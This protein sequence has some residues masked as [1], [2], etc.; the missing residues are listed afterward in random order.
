MAKQNDPYA[1]FDGGEKP[2]SSSEVAKSSEADPYARFEVPGKVQPP[3]PSQQ[4]AQQLAPTDIP[5]QGAQREAEPEAPWKTPLTG[6]KTEQEKADPLLKGMAQTAQAERE[7]AAQMRQSLATKPNDRMAWAMGTMKE[8]ASRMGELEVEI[9]RLETAI[10]NQRD[11]APGVRAKWQKTLDAATAEARAMRPEYDKALKVM[12]DNLYAEVSAMIDGKTGELYDETSSGGRVPNEDKVNE[13]TERLLQKYGMQLVT[14]KTV[15]MPPGAGGQTI[16]LVEDETVRPVYDMARAK[17]HASIAYA[18]DEKA[19]T[20]H[21]EK[22]IEERISKDPRL[23]QFKKEAETKRAAAIAKAQA[24]MDAEAQAFANQVKATA[25]QDVDAAVAPVSKQMLSVKAGFEA[26]DKAVGERADAVQAEY[27]AGRITYEQAQQQVA[28][29][30]SEADA[31]VKEANAE[32]ERLNKQML[33]SMSQVNAKYNKAFKERMNTLQGRVNAELASVTEQLSKEYDPVLAKEVA[34]IYANLY[35]EYYDAKAANRKDATISRWRSTWSNPMVAMANIPGVTRTGIELQAFSERFVESLGSFVKMSSDPGSALYNLGSRMET[36]SGLHP[37]ELKELGDIAEEGNIGGLAGETLGGMAVPIGASIAVGAATMGAGAPVALGVGLSSFASWATET[38]SLAQGEYN[39]AISEGKGSAQAVLNRDRLISAQVQAMGLYALDGLPFVQKALSGIASRG[40]RMLVAGATEFAT[41]VPQELTQGVFE[42]NI[43]NNAN[44]WDNFYEGLKR[45]ANPM[46]A[47]ASEREDWSAAKQTMLHLAFVPF[48]GAAGQVNSLSNK[49]EMDKQVMTFIAKTAMPASKQDRASW[50]ADATVNQSVEFAG[51]TIDS[52]HMSGQITATESAEL[53]RMSAAVDEAMFSAKNAGVKGRNAQAL[54]SFTAN[55]EQYRIMAETASDPVEKKAAEA[56]ANA[57]SNIAAEILRTGEASYVEM[58]WP[59]SK[60]SFYEVDEFKRLLSDVGFA[61]LAS[62]GLVKISPTGRAAGDISPMLEVIK[63]E[64]AERAAAR[65]KAAADA[66]QDSERAAAGETR[67]SRVPKNPTIADVEGFRVSLVTAGKLVEGYAYADGQTLVVETEAGV[68]YE[69]GNLEQLASEPASKFGISISDTRGSFN[70]NDDGS[71][72]VGNNAYVNNNENVLDAVEVDS[73]GNIIAVTLAT[74]DSGATGAQGQGYQKGSR[75]FKGQI[76]EDMAYEFYLQRIEQFP[77]EAGERFNNIINNE[78]ESHEAERRAKS[79]PR[80]AP[81]AKAPAGDAEADQGGGTSGESKPAGDQGKQQPAA[82]EEPAQGSEE[83]DGK[84][85]QADQAD[86]EEQDGDQVEASEYGPNASEH[87]DSRSLQ[88]L[89][90]EVDQIEA[91]T[92]EKKASRSRVSKALRDMANAMDALQAYA[93]I[94]RVVVHDTRESFLEA[95]KKH[96]GSGSLSAMKARG[97]M[98]TESGDIHLNVQALAENV[99]DQQSEAARQAAPT[100]EAAHVV[101]RAALRRNPKLGMALHADIKLMAK[102][103]PQVRMMLDWIDRVYK[104]RVSDHV[105]REEAIVEFVARVAQGSIVMTTPKGKSRLYDFLARIADALGLNKIARSLAS[106]SQAMRNWAAYVSRALSGYTIIDQGTMLS[107][108]EQVVLNSIALDKPPGIVDVTARGEF[109][110]VTTDDGAVYSYAGVNARLDPSERQALDEAK[111]QDGKMDPEEMRQRLGWFRGTHDYK[112]RTEFSD[113][114]AA[115]K[116]DVGE[117]IRAA[118]ERRWKS[119][120]PMERIAEAVRDD[121]DMWIPDG[122]SDDAFLA[123]LGQQMKDSYKLSE[124]LDHYELFQKYPAL[125]DV[126]VR[127]ERGDGSVKGEA[128]LVPDAYS[129]T[130]YSASVQNDFGPISTL[131]HEIQHIIQ[132]IEGFAQGGNREIAAQ[133]ATNDQVLRAAQRHAAS[134][135]LNLRINQEA[136]QIL[137]ATTK[138][139]AL[140]LQNLGEAVVLSRQAWDAIAGKNRA[141]GLGQTASEKSAWNKY[142]NAATRLSEARVRIMTKAGLESSSLHMSG[143]PMTDLS[144]VVLF[145]DEKML[146]RQVNDAGDMLHALRNSD[147]DALRGIVKSIDNVA[148]EMYRNLAGEI[149]ARDVQARMGMS[150]RERIATPPYSSEQAAKDD[151]IVAFSRAGKNV[152]NMLAADAAIRIFND[153]APVPL[154]A[155]DA[156]DVSGIMLS[157]D[158]DRETPRTPIGKTK[159]VMVDGKERPALNSNGKPIH[160][161]VEGVRN[162]WRWFGDSKVVDEQGRPKVMYHGATGD[163]GYY[164]YA[165]NGIFFT[166]S[167]DGASDL[168]TEVRPSRDNISR[169]LSSMTQQ[170]VADVLSRVNLAA[171]DYVSLVKKSGDEWLA[172]IPKT[173]PEYSSAK[174]SHESDVASAESNASEAAR[175]VDE[176]NSGRDITSVIMSIGNEN[177]GVLKILSD[178]MGSARASG[179]NL[180]PVYLRS[181]KVFDGGRSVDLETMEWNSVGTAEGREAVRDVLEQ[182]IKDGTI[183]DIDVS[184]T[185]QG[186]DKR[187]IIR[188]ELAWRSWKVLEQGPV[189][190]AIRKLGYDGFMTNEV[191][192]VNAVFNPTRIKSATGNNGL[193]SEG[194]DSIVMSASE[195][196]SQTPPSMSR[197]RFIGVVS[198]A[199]VAYAAGSLTNSYLNAGPLS[200]GRAAPIPDA[201]FKT[202]LSDDAIR[203]IKARPANGIGLVRDVL[204]E[205]SSSGPESL[206][207]LAADVLDKMPKDGSL[208]VRIVRS[209]VFAGEISLRGGYILEML[210]DEKEGLDVGTF[211]HESMHLVSVARY[212]SLYEAAK[213]EQNEGARSAIRALNDL[214]E[215]LPRKRVKG[216][217]ENEEFSLSVA[218][219][220]IEEF[221][222]RSLTDPFLQ[223]A[224]SKIE[225]RGSTMMDRFIGWVK[226]W[227][228][229]EGV[230]PSWLDASVIASTEAMKSMPAVESFSESG[231]RRFAGNEPV[232]SASESDSTIVVD[233]IER[234]TRNSDGRIIHPT[235]EGLTNFWR[236]YDGAALVDDDGAPIPMY[237][238][239]TYP[240]IEVFTE[241]GDP[242]GFLGPGPYFTNEPDD[243]SWNYARIGPDLESRILSLQEKILDDMTNDDD[244]AIE[245]LNDYYENHAHVDLVPGWQDEDLVGDKD[246][247]QK[248]F[249][250]HGDEASYFSAKRALVGPAE[251]GAIIPVYVAMKNPADV[252]GKFK[253]QVIR[254]EYETDSDG[255]IIDHDADSDLYRWLDDADTVASYYGVDIDKYRSAVLQRADENDGEVTIKELYEL[256]KEHLGW[257]E[258]NDGL[259]ITS[260]AIFR[261]TASE[262][263]FDGVIMDAGKEFGRNMKNVYADTI[264]AVPFTN[265]HNIVKSAIGNTGEFGDTRNIMMSAADDSLLD[266]SFKVKTSIEV[267][268]KQRPTRNSNGRL[269]HPTERGIKNFWGWFGDSKYVDELGRPIMF[270]HGTKGDFDEF[271]ARYSDGMI[272]LSLNPEFASNWVMQRMDGDPSRNYPDEAKEAD[273]KRRNKWIEERVVYDND[274]RYTH[275]DGSPM[276][277]DEFGQIL[278]DSRYQ[279][280][281]QFRHTADSSVMGVYISSSRPFDPTSDYALIEPLLRSMPSMDGIVDKEKHKEGHWIVYENDRVK[282]WL[283]SN[284]YDSVMVRE[285]S[286]EIGGEIETVNVWDN[287]RIKSATGNNGDFGEGGTIVLSGAAGSAGPS[288]VF[289]IH[290]AIRMQQRKSAMYG[291]GMNT[292][293][294][295]GAVVGTRRNVDPQLVNVV[296]ALKD[297][298]RLEAKAAEEGFKLGNFIGKAAGVAQGYQRGYKAG[299]KKGRY[300]ATKEERAAMKAARESFADR[301]KDILYGPK[302]PQ[303]GNRSGGLTGTLNDQQQRSIASKAVQVNPMNPKQVLRFLDYAERVVIDAHHDMKIG[304]AEDLVS[305]AKKLA[306]NKSIPLNH[307]RALEDIA[308]VT[309]SMIED[310]DAFLSD[311]VEYMDTFLPTSKGYLQGS[312]SKAMGAADIALK[313]AANH[314]AL[315]VQDMFGVQVAPEEALELYQI[316]VADPS[317]NMANLDSAKRKAAMDRMRMMAEYSRLALEMYDKSKL[318]NDADKRVVDRMIDVD[319]AALNDE[320][321][322]EYILAADNIAM[323]DA[324]YGA[325]R[326]VEMVAATQSFVAARDILSKTHIRQFFRGKFGALFQQ[327]HYSVSDT[328]RFMLGLSE[329]AAEFQTAIGWTDYR[330]A[331]T[332]FDNELN[333]QMESLMKFYDNLA[334]I[335]PSMHEP[336]VRVSEGMVGYM[337][338]PIPGYSEQESFKYR[339]QMLKQSIAN[340]YKDDYYDEERTMAQKVMATV[341]DPAASV[342]EMKVAYAKAYPSGME[343]LNFLAKEFHAKYRDEVLDFREKFWNERA[344]RDIPFYLPVTYKSINNHDL[345]DADE[346]LDR[347][348]LSNKYLQGPQAA[349]NTT[350][351]KSHV[352]IDE[353]TIIDFNIRRNSMKAMAESLYD[354]RTS[355]EWERMRQLMHMPGFADMVG[356][357][358]NASVLTG[359][360]NNARQA[361]LKQ[362]RQL[363]MDRLEGA[364][365]DLTNY[366]RRYASTVAL[367]GF[368]Q[369]IKQPADQL[370]NAIINGFGKNPMQAFIT[371]AESFMEV[372][373]AAPLL[374]LAS[375]GERGRLVGG[376]KWDSELQAEITRLGAMIKSGSATKAKVAAKMEDIRGLWMKAL[377]A[378]D[379]RSASTAWIMNYK[380]YMQKRGLTLLSWQEEADLVKDGDL[381]RRNAIAYAETMTDMTQGSS[382]PTNIA[383]L[384]QRG[385]TGYENMLKAIF[386]PFS[387]FT[388]QMRARVVNDISDVIYYKKVAWGSDGQEK[389]R[390]NQLSGRAAKSLAATIGAQAAYVLAKYAIA[391]TIVSALGYGL[392]QILGDDDDDKDRLLAAGATLFSILHTAGMMDAD[393]AR[394]FNEAVKME[395]ERNAGMGLAQMVSTRVEQ[396]AKEALTEFL[397]TLV[398]SGWL[399]GPVDSVAL[400]AMFYADYLIMRANNDERVMKKDGEPMEFAGWIKQDASRLRAYDPLSTIDWG[401]FGIVFGAPMAPVRNFD[402]M[403]NG[404][405]EA[406]AKGGSA[407]KSSGSSGIPSGRRSGSRRRGGGRTRRTR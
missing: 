184:W 81:N 46:S 196:G 166:D 393:V 63:Q 80:K 192:N 312:S 6:A 55:A 249:M 52:L 142:T 40:G 313:D 88:G 171:A 243:A 129:I 273:R 293:T 114:D 370:T 360:M 297:Q 145:G 99:T 174:E 49:Q 84:A 285:S 95:S 126:D 208:L 155:A 78:V 389:S 277:D 147:T 164:R 157:A 219:G 239:T 250:Q 191:G 213:S 288:S 100:H 308:R 271:R 327:Q 188:K 400:I 79:K 304:I 94:G 163:F 339:K 165:E 127:F 73:R 180:M 353:N 122:N 397:S 60:R 58:T 93:P 221:F 266:E 160:P 299:Q 341:I 185:S 407:K 229:R 120:G 343:S 182:L 365:G 131:M 402:A 5:M 38:N 151:V 247:T 260:T 217:S 280:D 364:L 388:I 123:N 230:A 349:A 170:G 111:S 29:L 223:S 33:D 104:G 106:D 195:D 76:A 329:E 215:E 154:D 132:H 209:N 16:N 328:F 290:G 295:T 375:I 22:R 119:G 183:D 391:K 51:A 338:Q 65:A 30:A 71:F 21:V 11:F 175:V 176:I 269:I 10:A 289:S 156:R 399:A 32:I 57:A 61:E 86:Q 211:L 345:L 301:V 144:E 381:D 117:A 258:D 27:N 274:G 43:G 395:K 233:G 62:S 322:R 214:W 234:P 257:G 334:A 320:Q 70:M 387:T 112:W 75:R 380:A 324:F 224:L 302:D 220:S 228:F 377:S 383:R 358:F 359:R 354:L 307:R 398:G 203:A 121:V 136:I 87:Y 235:R 103:D 306:R 238:G 305:K 363:S 187:Q 242:R 159:T 158:I 311:I 376:T 378:G 351:R 241:T 292:K 197:R 342:D 361:Q 352:S 113:A 89:A 252:T 186:F 379:T 149:E 23:Q 202:R 18:L 303:T 333:A 236:L 168:F 59:N 255:N 39:K 179:A 137:Q 69:V 178:I 20:E 248:A 35:G 173:D 319:V 204:S 253:S 133:V 7:V 298:I 284:G 9:N 205:I 31:K 68:M 222:V 281:G 369:I 291:R 37:L 190:D 169:N 83:G 357:G 270:Y 251:S 124:V 210:L 392:Q 326:T 240:S 356:G 141:A 296:A 362:S 368:T 105:L 54:A 1:R 53:K 314:Y 246:I 110:D 17:V 107:L 282:N 374:E 26:Y 2:K 315:L 130:L 146:Q 91:D 276:T 385:D 225:Y 344:D 45:P 294:A 66:K 85:E 366:A 267:D 405:G 279:Y 200:V 371:A 82:K 254:L 275:P 25:K 189:L 98:V 116:V 350:A 77:N 161:T 347:I 286:A 340:M 318:Q 72:Q 384:A 335:Y 177:R 97:F 74:R 109:V 245:V 207:S 14:A 198:A 135:E 348:N 167:A 108:G 330:L 372:G 4:P 226:G 317:A 162:F 56:S 373:E 386:N 336:E 24:T 193:W 28:A 206:R 90:D 404:V 310:L 115:L 8:R 34:D 316:L 44:P 264:H 331:K 367:G 3:S 152:P 346:R 12:N 278:S 323:N 259:Q 181:E 216:M 287:T 212:R 218:R 128:T 256:A 332:R 96:G 261:E 118:T 237:H 148:R 139:D 140:Q 201:D 401:L 134:I 231:L 283:S 172:G 265:K 325:Y 199:S 355:G 67:T 309:P 13:V 101:Y 138:R 406:R 92:D 19:V 125:R 382:D 48:I 47:D 396:R 36:A 394:A 268:G 272:S 390:A 232:F 150:N 153:N 102:R 300:E 262:Y 42:Y 143:H 41:E 321:L 227:L 337:L 263:G 194:N 244:Y 15:N 64:S 50:I 403:L